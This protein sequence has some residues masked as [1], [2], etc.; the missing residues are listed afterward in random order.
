MNVFTYYLAQGPTLNRD[1]F[2]HFPLLTDLARECDIVVELGVRE[3]G[4]TWA[5][6]SGRPKE[7]HS[8]DLHNPSKWGGRLD[9]VEI[10]AKQVGTSFTFYEQDVLTADIPECDLILFDT[11]HTYKQLKKELELH[12]NKS[13]KYL[14]FHDVVS[15]GKRD[16]V[17]KH[18]HSDYK[19]EETEK[20]GLIAAIE[21]FVESNKEWRYHIFHYFNNG[22][23]VLK[24]SEQSSL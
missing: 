8:Y 16:E 12:A 11:W 10:G 20:Q 6:L 7:L 2:Q 9:H 18:E 22:L 24:R 23:L 13:R 1:I 15:Y 19:F 14:V 3:I 4:S 21:E 5:F 17:D